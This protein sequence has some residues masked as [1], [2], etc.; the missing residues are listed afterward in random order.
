MTKNALCFAMALGSV[1][2]HASVVTP[3]EFT[4]QSTILT[5]GSNISA[6][7]IRFVGATSTPDGKFVDLVDGSFM[8]TDQ[9]YYAVKAGH[10]RKKV[11]DPAETPKRGDIAWIKIGKSSN[12]VPHSPSMQAETKGY[13]L[14]VAKID[15]GAL[16]IDG[17]YA[18]ERLWVAFADSKGL[19]SVYSG[20]L[21]I[22]DMT[23]VQFSECMSDVTQRVQKALEA[24]PTP[25]AKR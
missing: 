4:I 6:C 18:K 8:F 13:K 12:V 17:I 20:K 25:E 9:V 22:D 5:N 1:V 2:A 7:G 10:F 16:A 21:N 23:M 14:F 11:G 24:S 19:T 15:E 3:V